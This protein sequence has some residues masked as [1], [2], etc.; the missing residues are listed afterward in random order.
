MR[1]F[2]AASDESN[3]TYIQ[4]IEVEGHL[5]AKEIVEIKSKGQVFGDIATSKLTVLEGGIFDGKSSMLKTDSNIVDFQKK[6]GTS[7]P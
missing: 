4:E 1:A 7:S 2:Q 5:I 6:S 3:D